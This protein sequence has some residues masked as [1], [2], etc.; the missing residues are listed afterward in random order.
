MKVTL[1]AVVVVALGASSAWAQS[2]EIGSG[3]VRVRPDSDRYERREFRRDRERG[4][5]QRGERCR[6]VVVRR[7]TRRGTVTERRRECR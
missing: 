6:T 2:F 1:A 3:G 7:E 5:D 4:W